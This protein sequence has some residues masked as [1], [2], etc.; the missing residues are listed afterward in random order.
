MPTL[1]AAPV[2]DRRLRAELAAWTMAAP[3]TSCAVV[4]D[5]EGELVLAHRPDDPVLPAST[6]KRLTAAAV[7]A[8]LGPDHRF[9]TRALAPEPVDGAIRGDLVLV[10]GGDPVLA[11][12]DYASRFRRQPQIFTDLEDL[13]VAVAGAGI[14]RVEGA[15]VGDESRYDLERYRPDWPARYVSGGDVGPLSA[16]SVND[17][18]AEYP[19]SEGSRPLVPAADP[20]ASAAAT[21]TFLLEVHGVDVVGPP[22]AG[23]APAGLSEV[24][25][26]ES[27]P[28]REVVTQLLQESDNN[29]AELLLKELGRAAGA[30]TTA[31][32]LARAADALAVEGIDLDG[33]VLAD[34]SGL[35]LDNRLTC[36]LLVDVLQHPTTGPALRA[37]LPVAGRSGTLTAAFVGTPLEGTLAA[38]TGSL[39]SVAALAGIVDDEDEPLTFA[40]VANAPSGQVVDARAVVAAQLR[41]GEILAAWPRVPDVDALG[42][43]PVAAR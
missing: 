5:P 6:L 38:K 19:T 28:L 42:P 29:P 12:A 26:L 18:W 1:V 8:E 17:G 31:G 14:T 3:E 33:M 4:A 20:A 35:S 43:R 37:A 27:A 40:Y 30:P 11:S 13:A 41:L 10:G 16:L 25:V 7:L 39:N 2:A 23:L 9:R 36:D 32:G 22:R 34:G 15:V 21:F 24:A